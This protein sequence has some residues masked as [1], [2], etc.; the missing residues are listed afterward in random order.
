MCQ[1]DFISIAKKTS[2]S[3]SVIVTGSALE[4]TPAL[5]TTP[6]KSPCLATN[7]L[8]ACSTS[9]KLP[10][11][12]RSNSTLWPAVL[13][14]PRYFSEPATSIS[15]KETRAP[16]CAASSTIAAPIPF[17]PPVTKIWSFGNFMIRSLSLLLAQQ[18]PRMRPHLLG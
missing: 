17:A 1:I 14:S 6:V 9:A 16:A 13:N 18:Q 11:S 10:T 2:H 12:A 7:F 8:S 4:P 5:F 3:S 15:T